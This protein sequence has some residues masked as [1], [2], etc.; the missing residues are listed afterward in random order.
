MG[1]IAI[2]MGDPAGIGPEIILKAYAEGA[3]SGAIPIVIGDIKVLEFYR[4]LLGL[5]NVHLCEI[6]KFS[7]AQEGVLN[8]LS[9]TNLN[10]EQD[11]SPGKSTPACGEA[12]VAYIKKAVDLCLKKEADAMVTAPISKASMHQ[13]GYNYPGHT[14]LLAELTGTDNYAMMLVGGGVRTVLV[15][16]HV[17]LKDVP[18]L[19]STEEVY[20]VAKLTCREMK[21]LYGIK[22]PRVAVCGLNPHAGEN[23]A[24]G[25]EEISII[26]PTIE[27]LRCERYEVSGPHPADTVFTGT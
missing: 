14:E 21:R 13:A 25:D 27:R 8:V 26:A 2:T 3:L 19:I 9:V 18:S 15:T 16:I 7:E 1:R 11:F 20:R 6:G 12:V 5:K 10:P 23:G 4:R 17:A 24:F 22:N